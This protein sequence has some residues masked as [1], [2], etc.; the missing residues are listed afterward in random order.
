MIN[1]IL[2]LFTFKIKIVRI[3]SSYVK[4]K[5]LFANKTFPSFVL[6]FC[7]KNDEDREEKKQ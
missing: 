3:L 1:I 4:S 6:S 2:Y 5:F 7:N